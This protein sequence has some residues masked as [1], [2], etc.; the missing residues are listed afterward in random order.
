MGG[1]GQTPRGEEPPLI[2]SNITREMTMSGW[3][4]TPGAVEERLRRLEAFMLGSRAEV[5]TRRL[6]VTDG[7]DRE[8]IVGEVAGNTAELRVDLPERTT[9]GR[10]SVLCFANAGDPELDLGWG[11]GI[12]LWVEGEVVDEVT[13]WWRLDGGPHPD[14]GR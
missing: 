5:R 12:Q 1:E 7:D 6:V 10:S 8:R 14:W 9:E 3:A 2:G 11:L 4:L 13:D